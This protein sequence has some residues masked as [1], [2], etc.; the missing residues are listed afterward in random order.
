MAA[1]IK[2]LD[3]HE[4]PSDHLRGIWKTYA[5]TDQEDLL[6]TVDID[7]L[8]LPEKAAEFC[9]ASAIPADQLARCFNDFL[10]AGDG[11][12][13]G[14][15]VHVDQDAPIYYHPLLPG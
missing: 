7:D 3:A 9:Q 4:Q 13:D 1:D 11:D 15:S 8:A 12:G 6:R 14:L 10:R 5:K 2:S